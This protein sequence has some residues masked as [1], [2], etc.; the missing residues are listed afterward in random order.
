M[1][2][3]Y[4][5]TTVETNGVRTIAGGGTGASTA[6]GA[7]AALSLV[8]ADV[9]LGNID[10][11]ADVNKPVS[12]ATQ[13]A[14]NLKVDKSVVGQPSGV[15][16]LGA[17]GKVPVGQLPSAVMEYLGVW[18]A[19]SNTPT[20]TD[21]MAGVNAGSMYTVSASGTVT[22]GTGNTIT[23]SV[24]DWVIHDGTKWQRS[25]AGDD[26]IS[27][28]GKTGA[29]ILG[30]SDIQGLSSALSSA[31][32]GL[33]N[34]PNYVTV[35]STA[36]PATNGA[37]LLAA[38][39]AAKALTPNGAALSAANRAIVFLPPG[40]Y[41]T[42][43]GLQLN[44]QY[45]DIVGL[46]TDASHAVIDKVNQ[47]A[48]D[49]RVSNITVATNGCTLASNL[50]LTIWTN[51]SV[52]TNTINGGFGT[53]IVLSGTFNNCTGTALGSS[54]SG[55]NPSGNYGG[56][57]FV[58][59]TAAGT[60]TNCTGIATSAAGYGGGFAGITSSLVGVFISC[61]GKANGFGC[62]GF[63]GAFGS[64]TG[65]LYNC[66]GDN[67]AHGGGGFVGWAP[68]SLSGYFVNCVG[69]SYGPDP[70]YPGAGILAYYSNIIT[71]TATY[72]N[73]TSLT[74][75]GFL[76]LNPSSTGKVR[77]YT[78]ANGDLFDFN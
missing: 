7:K 26:V 16:G 77:N 76:N 39:T 40:T 36:D 17:D 65:T 68:S 42:G 28:N 20:L 27:V 73:C 13:T 23:F 69:N 70:T 71:S 75:V 44:A 51:C 66:K 64:V 55:S 10:N 60:F 63:I 78:D 58:R 14:L 1:N 45:V 11:T 32:G 41:T 9:G 43:T 18:S 34:T 72:I 35:S 31:G 24:G 50:S 21:G 2:T 6:A 57:G 15:A 12:N 56:G 25:P 67:Y 53:S 38:Y 61:T 4:N 19:A 62:G 5:G 47:T 33:G 22:F 54:Y 74:D 8:K 48:N 3:L 52:S 46:S 30:I 37:N 59:G 49:V 29:V